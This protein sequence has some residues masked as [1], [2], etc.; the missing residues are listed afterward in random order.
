VGLIFFSLAHSFGAVLIASGD[1]YKMQHSSSPAYKLPVH[2]VSLQHRLPNRSPLICVQPFYDLYHAPQQGWPLLALIEEF[3]D[4]EMSGIGTYHYDIQYHID[5]ILDSGHTTCDGFFCEERRIR[6]H[7][8]TR[9]LSVFFKK[10]TFSFESIE[11]ESF[12]DTIFPHESFRFPIPYKHKFS[13]LEAFL[14]YPS[15]SSG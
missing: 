1:V 6:Q 5:T 9:V 4:Y 13:S 12:V 2:P 8:C 11:G 10:L 3:H 15:L 14:K 7:E